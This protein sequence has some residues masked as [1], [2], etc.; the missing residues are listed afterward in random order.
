MNNNPNEN[1]GQ[2]GVVSVTNTN[3]V[4]A[5]VQPNVGISSPVVST[6]APVEQTATVL[7]QQQPVS[8]VGGIP[9]STPVVQLG[10]SPIATQSPQ[11]AEAI[12]AQ[13]E[14]Q[15]AVAAAEVKAA[16]VA[17]QQDRVQLVDTKP[18]LNAVLLNN[19]TAVSINSTTEGVSED[20]EVL[21][22]VEGGT[23][24]GNDKKEKSHTF[25]LVVLFGGLLLLVIFLPE[26]SSYIDTQKY[27]KE[28]P[29]EEKITTGT[30]SCTSKS[31]DQ[32]FDF[33]YEYSVVFND[34]RVTKITA[35][36]ETKGDASLDEEELDEMSQNCKKLKGI[37]EQI[38]GISV[39]CNLEG[40]VFTKRQVF[41]LSSIVKDDAITAYIEAG[42]TYINYKYGDDIKDVESDLLSSNFDCKREK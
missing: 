26:I 10:S 8:A 38:D 1:N 31:S 28:N 30:L 36:T 11:T 42:G 15:A 21:D 12:V 23:T 35:T 13:V 14:Q 9:Q 20:T 40:G 16:P 4:S 25:G 33:F 34:E 7:P 18:K 3:T 22:V 32:K 27:L 19:G 39:G 5:T 6:Q 41:E 24:A 2:Q 29:V 37:V 17:P